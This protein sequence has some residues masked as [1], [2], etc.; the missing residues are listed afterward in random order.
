MD[1]VDYLIR[2]HRA[3]E[4]LFDRFN[5]AYDP[6]AKRR[7]VNEMIRLLSM[8]T[9]IEERF[10]YPLC[11]EVILEDGQG[12]KLSEHGIKEHHKMKVTLDEL[13]SLDENTAAF[14]EKVAHLIKETKH[15]H[16]DEEGEIFP[17]LRKSTTKERLIHFASQLDSAKAIAPTHPHPS[18]PDRPPFN[19][20]VTPILSVAD[21]IMDQTRLFPGDG[22]ETSIHKPGEK[23]DDLLPPN[24]SDKLG[25][26]TK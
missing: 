16:G 25:S 14:N 6:T 9:V 11:K 1:G 7:L 23:L 18:A 24:P 26:A 10:L 19:T 13:L 22:V 17:L 15:H 2:D 21:K 20:L 12:E 5:Q 8:H 3:I 4:E